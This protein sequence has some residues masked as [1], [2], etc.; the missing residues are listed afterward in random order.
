MGPHECTFAINNRATNASWIA[1]YFFP[2]LKINPHLTA[3]EMEQE[4]YLNFELK[5]NV[6]IIYRARSLA[7]MHISGTLFEHYAKLGQYVSELKRID[8]EGRFE[9]MTHLLKGI[10]CLIE[11]T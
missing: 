3:K 9:L 1:E 5:R 8:K 6:P 4:L 10:E 11:Y 2:K 7:M